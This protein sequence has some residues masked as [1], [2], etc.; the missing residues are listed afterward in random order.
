MGDGLRDDIGLAHR[1]SKGLGGPAEPSRD[2]RRSPRPTGRL[3]CAARDGVIE[4][5]EVTLWV[6]G[7]PYHARCGQ[8]RDAELRRLERERLRERLSPRSTEP[9]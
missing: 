2:A 4:A 7:E 5:G 1:L 6:E 3:D 8:E 9:S